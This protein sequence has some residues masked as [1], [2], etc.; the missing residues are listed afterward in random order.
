MKSLSQLLQECFHNDSFLSL[1]LSNPFNK[2]EV[3]KVIIRPV[4][5]QSTLFFQLSETKGNQI[6]HKN[7]S[8]KECL[9]ELNHSLLHQ[10]KQG[11]LVTK[12]ESFQFLT[13]RKGHTTVVKKV[14]QEK[15]ATLL[16]HDRVKNHILDEGTPLP[17]LVRLGVMTE[18][19]K[20][21]SQ[22]MA[23]FRQINRFLELVEDLLEK[24]KLE[25][26]NLT[27]VDFGCGKAYLTFALYYFLTE[28]KKLEVK[29]IGLDRKSDLLKECQ[30]IANDLGYSGLTFQAG[31]VTHFQ[32]KASV[33]MVVALHLCDTATDIALAK[34]IEW[35][36]NMI[37]CAPC[38]QHELYEQVKSDSL[39]ALL[40]YGILKERFAA[41]ATDAARA[42]ILE[43]KGYETQIL[44]FIDSEHTPKNLL[45]R[46]T[47]GNSQGNKQKALEYYRHLKETLKIEPSLE[48]YLKLSIPL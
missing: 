35:E 22:K 48:R 20:V 46:A 12:E 43:I 9:E 24:K 37:L 30:Q 23:K 19:G 27:I 21:V 28:I 18:S 26:K 1:T 4:M 39:N 14:K 36:C 41:L 11:F 42:Q 6:F 40:H 16:Q 25:K 17:F 47:K 34:A 38:C 15:K 7:L 31:D 3:L 5:I 44:E 2:Q 45:I 10:F 32:I 29:L 33:D 8:K 13:N